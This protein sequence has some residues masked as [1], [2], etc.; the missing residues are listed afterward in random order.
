MLMINDNG[1][2]KSL[3]EVLM[4]STGSKFILRNQTNLSDMLLYIYIIEHGKW[5]LISKSYL[6]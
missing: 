6:L 2:I 4:N 5:I 3:F 1:N